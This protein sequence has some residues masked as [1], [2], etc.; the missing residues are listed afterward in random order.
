MKPMATYL[1]PAEVRAEHDRQRRRENRVI[2]FMVVTLVIG[3]LL[4]GCIDREPLPPRYK[5]FLNG[6]QV[7]VSD[8]VRPEDRGNGWVVYNGQ[9]HRVD[10]CFWYEDRITP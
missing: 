1:L 2:A 10:A 4:A 7:Y 8:D 6:E 5:C 3:V 9:V